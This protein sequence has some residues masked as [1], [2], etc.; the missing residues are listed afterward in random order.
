MKIKLAYITLLLFLISAPVLPQNKHNLTLEDAIKIAL[1]NNPGIKAARTQI[2]AAKAKIKQAK[3]FKVPKIDLLTKYFYA[4][5]LPGMF[6]QD[7]KQAPVMSST[8]PVAGQFVPIR[9]L[10]PFP[11]NN[12]DVFTTDLNL[13]FP[14]YTGKKISTSNENA[15]KLK[16]AAQSDLNEKKADLVLKVKTAFFNILFLKKAININELALKQFEDHFA[17]AKKAYEEGVRSE[18]AVVSFQSRIEEFK[19]KLIDLKGK[20][21]LA[22]SGLKSLLNLP[23]SDTLNCLGEL[24]IEENLQLPS[25][26]KLVSDVNEQNNQLKTLRIKQEMVKNLETIAAAGN[27]PTVF[28]FGNY[29][30]IHGM[31]F[32]PY[33]NAWR[34][35]LALGMGLKMSIFD[36][37]YTK[38]K[39][40]EVKT[41]EALLKNYEEG[42]KLKLKFEVKQA[43]IKINSLQ[44]EI[45]AHLVHL[46]V[47]KK[48]YE[49]ANV[50][51]E[52]G[53]ITP[54]ELNDA[55]LQLTAIETT[56]AKYQKDIN[57]ELAKLEYLNGNTNQ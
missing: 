51:F 35:G 31:D 24:N 7:L 29:H 52:N 17:L 10:A 13:I 18:F 15:M 53:I 37:E 30:I 45:R 19:A 21:D 54:V 12:R 40:E 38:G 2:D 16:N 42:L 1:N 46:D 4:N 55:H 49:I 32:P 33:D 43:L 25:L 44:E 22:E 56:L 41:T 36:G 8:G 27:K 26:Q 14:I 47:A 5:N 11:D 34:N 28:L 23:I 3:S 57:I 39:V 6:P 9:P 20:L 50:S 48:A